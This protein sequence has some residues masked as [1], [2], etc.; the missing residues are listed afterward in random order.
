MPF[1]TRFVEHEVILMVL[2]ENA[3][4]ESQLAEES[5]WVT[6]LATTV[7][8]TND[9]GNELSVNSTADVWYWP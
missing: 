7:A 5:N 1:V 8:T 3:I 9:V 6:N 2:G 4:L